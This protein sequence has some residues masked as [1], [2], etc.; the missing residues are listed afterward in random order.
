MYL[1]FVS[2]WNGFFAV[3]FPSAYS[4]QEWVTYSVTLFGSTGYTLER[5]RFMMMPRGWN[6]REVSLMLAIG[7]SPYDMKFP[8]PSPRPNQ[9]R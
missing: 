8:R 3:L 4:Y 9:S 7:Y 6:K 5:S 1:G 2:P